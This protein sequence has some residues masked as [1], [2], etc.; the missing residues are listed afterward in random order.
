MVKELTFKQKEFIKVYLESFGN[1]TQA[2][3]IAYKCDSNTAGVIGYQNLRKLN[4]RRAIDN[5]LALAGVNETI[6][7]EQLKPYITNGSIESIKLACKLS[8]Y[9]S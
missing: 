9:I 8:G 2:A 5:I 3:R 4:I 6:I 1:A 7:A